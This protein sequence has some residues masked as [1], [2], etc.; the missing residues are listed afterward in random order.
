MN[1]LLILYCTYFNHLLQNRKHSDH[2]KPESNQSGYEDHPDSSYYQ[3]SNNTGFLNPYTENNLT[4]DISSISKANK[5][6]RESEAIQKDSFEFDS[7]NDNDMIAEAYVEFY[8]SCPEPNFKKLTHSPI[9][10]S[11]RN[12][13]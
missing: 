8:L 9:A 10:Y 13:G 1:I 5:F 12:K 2:T 6:G 4:D 7:K 3:K 11:W